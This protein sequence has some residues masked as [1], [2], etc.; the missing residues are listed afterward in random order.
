MYIFFSLSLSLPL[1][2]L[3]EPRSMGK[4]LGDQGKQLSTNRR[5]KTIHKII[6]LTSKVVLDVLDIVWNHRQGD[7]AGICCFKWKTGIL[8]YVLPEQTFRQRF[9]DKDF[10]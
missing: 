7:C 3:A 4:W 5:N 10:T 1:Q 8:I 2:Y 9:E 6:R